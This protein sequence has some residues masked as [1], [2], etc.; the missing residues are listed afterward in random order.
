[1][2]KMRNNDRVSHIQKQAQKTE[3]VRATGHTG[4]HRLVGTLVEKQFVEF[5]HHS[6]IKPQRHADSAMNLRASVGFNPS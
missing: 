5:H 1:M 3:A 4:D 6:V 2:I